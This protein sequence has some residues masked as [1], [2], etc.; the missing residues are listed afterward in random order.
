ME[1]VLFGC[2]GHIVLG[3]AV[4]IWEGLSLKL[5]RCLRQESGPSCG[6]W[7]LPHSDYSRGPAVAS[8]P[9]HFLH[10]CILC[11]CTHSLYLLCWVLAQLVS[12]QGGVLMSC[13]GRG[14]SLTRLGS[15]VRTLHPSPCMPNPDHPRDDK[16]GQGRV[17]PAHLVRP[18]ILA[19]MP[20]V[21]WESWDDIQH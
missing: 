18:P 4:G 5:S 8:S 2:E 15:S 13:S 19:R 16:E 11:H 17:V 6:L 12:S 21:C 10:P 3:A 14:S 20:W 1:I 9:R 7:P